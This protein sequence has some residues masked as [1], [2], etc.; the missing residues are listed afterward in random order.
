MEFRPPLVAR[1]EEAEHGVGRGECGVGGEKAGRRKGVV[2]EAAGDEHGGVDDGELT[3]G[4]ATVGQEGQVR[5]APDAAAREAG[6]DDSARPPPRP[7]APCPGAAAVP[8]PHS[9]PGTRVWERGR[10]TK[11]LKPW[12]ATS[13]CCPI[14]SPKPASSLPHHPYRL[15]RPSASSTRSISSSVS[16][17]YDVQPMCSLTSNPTQFTT[18]SVRNRDSY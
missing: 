3:R 10:G 4:R 1:G 5:P 7:S 15:Y 6:V 18:K 17:R 9:L 2:G 8:A 12:R 11:E 13:S 14:A 16:N